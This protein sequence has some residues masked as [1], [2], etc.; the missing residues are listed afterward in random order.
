MPITLD[1]SLPE[2]L[3]PLAWLIGSWEG[4]GALSGAGDAPDARLEQQLVCTAREDGA[5]DWRSTI[6]RI[7]AP[8]PL[9][10][11]S[12]FARDVESPPAPSG[13]GERTLLHREDGVWT[14]GELLPGQDRAAAE[15]ARPGAPEGFLSHRLTAQLTRR[16]EQAE[17]WAGEVRGPRI[18]L[19]LADG[20]G[21]VV[22]TRML[23][24]ISGRLMWLWE[25]R[26]PVADGAPGETALSPYLSLELHRV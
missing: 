16:G 13:T 10:P 24:Y 21:E 8:A 12:A 7:D 26:G 18:Q 2:S 14:V 17:H 1:T 23:G 11:T 20:A 9:P 6:H 22:A 15:A 19:A 25:R 5:L 4:S 3:Y